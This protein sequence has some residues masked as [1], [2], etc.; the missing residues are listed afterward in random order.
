MKV[1]LVQGLVFS[2]LV[3]LIAACQPKVKYRGSQTGGHKPVKPTVAKFVMCKTPRP[4][5]C[6]TIFKP[7]CATKDT[8]VRCVKAPCPA[9]KK[10]TYPNACSACVDKKVY[11]YLSGGACKD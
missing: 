11:G 2:A 1:S 6:A 8:G 3:I 4:E 7:V 9:T 10:V 5:I